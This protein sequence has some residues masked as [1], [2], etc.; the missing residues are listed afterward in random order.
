MKGGKKKRDIRS[1]TTGGSAIRIATKGRV[2]S[3]LEKKHGDLSTET[4]Y[5]P[6]EDHKSDL[7]ISVSG[8]RGII[9]KSLTPEIVARYAAAFGTWA[10]GGT[11]I[12]GRDSRVSG[13]MIKNTVVSS[14]EATG[15][16]VVDVG[17]VPTPTV[18]IAVKNLG[19]HGG[20]AI[21][22]SHNPVEWNALKL[23]GP[24]GLFLDQAGIDEVV[25][26]AGGR[27][28]AYA[29]WDHLGKTEFYDHAIQNHID[30]I[31]ELEFL[32]LDRIREKKFKVAVDCVNGT[33]ALIAPRLLASLGCE[34]IL[35]NGECH[36]IFSRN[37]EPVVENLYALAQTV[38][39]CQCDIGFALDP[40]AD[41]V[42]IV[43]ELG[44]AIG[45]EFSLA[46]A[47]ELI[48]SQRKQPVVVN[49]STS[50]MIDDIAAKYGVTVFR[51]KIGEI[52]VSK[53]MMETKALIGGEG[54]G[55]VIVPQVHPGRDAATGMALVLQLMCQHNQPL[56]QILRQLPVTSMKK[57]KIP[58]DNMNADDLASRLEGAYPHARMDRTDGIKILLKD[59]WLHFRKSNTEP[60]MRIIAE[61]RDMNV[62][63]ELIDTFT[64]IFKK[65]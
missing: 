58:Y 59:A 47:V 6:P 37:P 9:G 17:I 48:L 33:G 11:I 13:P 32:Q 7:M 50:M 24:E 51:T 41:R 8:I 42:A 52:N 3:V 60:V 61:A 1:G 43:S 26:I 63:D 39:D 46:L 64:K 5:P 2:K 53:K 62:T 27:R 12:V 56:S 25:E 10:N 36:G 38:R 55:G 44:E 19:A 23:I 4:T 14:L 57:T 16:R 31:M 34:V 54:N 35:V 40:D 49:V 21:T 18:E 20:I 28:F 65:A 45:E 15:C 22:A 29:T 30:R